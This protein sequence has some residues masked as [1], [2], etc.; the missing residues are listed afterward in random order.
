MR[1]RNAAISATP[2]TTEP[3]DNAQWCNLKL[4]VDVAATGI[5][6][7]VATLA[8]LT[9]SSV[10]VAVSQLET[11]LRGRLFE[12]A[13]VVSVKLCKLAARCHERQRIEADPRRRS[14]SMHAD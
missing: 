1:N 8:D 6:S 12:C 2:E 9:Q 10:S 14:H 3:G 5:F 4:F 7:H 11:E 13:G